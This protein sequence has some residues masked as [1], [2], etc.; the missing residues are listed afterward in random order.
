MLDASTQ[1]LYA[2]SLLSFQE[3]DAI[4]VGFGKNTPS[5]KRFVVYGYSCINAFLQTEPKDYGKL[6]EQPCEAVSDEPA[7]ISA[8]RDLE[9]LFGLFFRRRFGF[10]WV[11]EGGSGL[12][13]F[14]TLRDLMTLYREG[15]IK[16][17]LRVG[18]VASYPIVSMPSDSNIK[19]VLEL[20]VKKNNR[21]IMI[22]GT[23][24]VVSDREIIDHIFSTYRLPGASQKPSRVLDGKLSDLKSKQPRKVDLELRIDE[25]VGMIYESGGCL[26]CGDGIVTPWDLTIKPWNEKKISLNGRV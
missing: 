19:D 25:A 3:I 18:D 1:T 10:A 11:E 5:A 12:G 17:D 20:M 2:L 15:K 23:E 9:N 24:S 21:R 7:T 4:P 6:L 13:G 8:E 22:S 14:A 16:T 26:T